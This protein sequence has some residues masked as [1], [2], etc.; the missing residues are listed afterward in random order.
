M[1]ETI[2][3]SQEEKK[4][5]LESVRRLHGEYKPLKEEINHLREVIGLNR[6]DETDDNQTID[7]FLRFVK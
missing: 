6:V 3:Q 5:A 7:S 4:R 2:K 1:E